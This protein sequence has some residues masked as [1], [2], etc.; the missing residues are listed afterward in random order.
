MLKVLLHR[1][2]ILLSAMAA[3]LIFGNSIE[4][5]SFIN[6]PILVLIMTVAVTETD[7]KQFKNIKRALKP[8]AAGIFLNYFL[9]FGLLVTLGRLMNLDG[10]LWV[11]LVIT[12]ATPPGLAIMPFTAVVGGSMFY[13][14]GATF[15]AFI[16]TLIFTPWLTTLLSGSDIISFSAIFRLFSLM[17]IL[18]LILGSIFRAL[19]FGDFAKKIHGNVV[20][21]GFGLIFAVISGINRDIMFA[22]PEYLIKLILIFLIGVF[23][24]VYLTKYILL[25]T[26]IDKEIIMSLLIIVGIKNSIFGAA[27]GY[28]LIGPLAAAP[29]TVMTFVIFIYLMLIEKVVGS[30][31]EKKTSLI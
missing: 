13:A 19:G 29:G 7:L 26:S 22:H 2:F 6:I 16:A 9:I 23:G 15:S 31:P 21:I 8:F 5:L 10:E 18:P 24:I 17:I 3:G 4:W 28:E 11:G 27:A 1:N 30:F 20:N 12:A 25:K 14:A